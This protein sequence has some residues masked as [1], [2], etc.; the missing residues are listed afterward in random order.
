MPLVAEKSGH[1][2]IAGIKVRGRAD[3][4][5]MLADGR[6]AIVDYKTGE[7]PNN[8]QVAAGFAMQ[9]GLIGLIAEQGGFEGAVG[10]AGA[11]EY[12]SLARDPRT[13]QFGKVTS[14]VSGRTAVSDPEKFVEFIAN[15]FKT[16]AAKWL[17]GNEPFKAKLRPEYAW[18]D[19]DQLMR[20]EEWQGRD[21]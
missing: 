17:T 8:K 15:K 12:W 4:I 19:Y 20:L 6:L 11:F 3:R 18:A 5:D 9:L 16:A 2:D 13:G 14:P 10:K 1:A 7:G 21:V